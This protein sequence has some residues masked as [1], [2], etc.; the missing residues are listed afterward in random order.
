MVVSQRVWRG[1]PTVAQLMR[2]RDHAADARF[3]VSNPLTR[4]QPVPTSALG[5]S[6]LYDVQSIAVL[7]GL[8]LPKL[9]SAAR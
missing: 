5:R 2:G 7:V 4:P 3:G 1:S 6:D 9:S 8:V